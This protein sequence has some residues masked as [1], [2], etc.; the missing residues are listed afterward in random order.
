MQGTGEANFL[1]GVARKYGAPFEVESCKKRFFE[2]Y[3]SKYCVPGGCQRPFGRSSFRMECLHLAP[4]ALTS[5]PT[6]Q[7]QACTNACDG[8][9]SCTARHHSCLPLAHRLS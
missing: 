2:I 3:L 4:M 8:H 5:V 1:G 6:Q 9:G 7:R